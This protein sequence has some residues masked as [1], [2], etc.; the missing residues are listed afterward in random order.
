M[1]LNPLLSDTVAQKTRRLYVA[2]G[3]KKKEGKGRGD[4]RYR[5]KEKKRGKDRGAVE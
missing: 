4:E 3:S 2:W 1:E 5:E